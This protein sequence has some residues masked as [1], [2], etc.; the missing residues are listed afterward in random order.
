MISSQVVSANILNFAS[1]WK[2]PVSFSFHLENFLLIRLDFN[3]F[4]QT[5]LAGKLKLS[6]IVPRCCEMPLYKDFYF[7]SSLFFLLFSFSS[8]F[9]SLLFFLVNTTF[10]IF[11]NILDCMKYIN[12]SENFQ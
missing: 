3:L 4:S 7:H 6:R 10:C 2:I 9:L 11:K 5:Y 8:F 1:L 12:S